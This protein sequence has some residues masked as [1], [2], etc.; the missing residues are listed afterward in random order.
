MHVSGQ[1]E[2]QIYQ[3]LCAYG[4]MRHALFS[5]AAYQPGCSAALLPGSLV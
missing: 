1:N 2:K 4:T 3:H 5:L